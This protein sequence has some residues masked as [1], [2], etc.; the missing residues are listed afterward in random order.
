MSKWT[1]APLLLGGFFAHGANSTGATEQQPA[2]VN[3][4]VG[5]SAGFQGV[6][7]SGAVSR[8]AEDGVT[9]SIVN[10]CFGTNLRYVDNPVSPQG[11]VKFGF[12]LLDKGN[13]RE[14]SV[15]YSGSL[16]TEDGKETAV[17][18]PADAITAPAGVNV[19]GAVYGNVVRLKVPVGITVS[20][21]ADGNISQSQI[22]TSIQDLSFT[23]IFNAETVGNRGPYAGPYY[24]PGM[25]SSHS[26]LDYRGYNGALSASVEKS[27]SK[28]LRQITINARFPGEFG[29]CGGFFSPLMVFFDK[30]LPKFTAK[31]K[32]PL[33]PK[34]LTNWPEKGSKGALVAMDRNGDGKI[35]SA[36]EL[37]GDGQDKVKNGFEALRELDS[38]K[39]G[40]IDEKDKDFG[41]LVLWFD[42]NAD[43]VSQKEELV[44]LKSRIKSISLKYES[45][46]T[47]IKDRA[48][49]RERG[50]FVFVENGKEKTGDIIDVWFAAGK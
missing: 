42:K 43:G 38:N 41:K 40:V 20:V 29:F 48:E 36:N 50:T 6:V 26:G 10:S 4:G 34:G 17:A 8:G 47:A 30:D 2:S 25:K 33:N 14:F 21:D 18:I 23:Q 32:F 12:K 3:S 31:V 11:I 46:T 9:V 35:T 24:K 49:L 27:T 15:K 5:S 37:F 7:L 28:D 16:V 39:D 22:D 45:N 13:L 1:L 19:T 44:P